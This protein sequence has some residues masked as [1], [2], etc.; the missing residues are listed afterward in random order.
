MPQTHWQQKFKIHQQFHQNKTNRCIHL[1]FSLMQL[2]LLIK[3]ISVASLSLLHV[4]VSLIFIISLSLY[5]L[6]I[7]KTSAI[8]MF[9]YLILVLSLMST[10][11]FTSPLWTFSFCLILFVMAALCQVKIGHG[12]FEQGRDNLK[13]EMQEFKQTKD[14]RIFLLIYLFPL[15]HTMVYRGLHPTLK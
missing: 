3:M 10:L 9:F 12:I 13:I 6:T 8:V 5:Y 1:V 2:A 14:I 11:T 15:L 7:D 4:D